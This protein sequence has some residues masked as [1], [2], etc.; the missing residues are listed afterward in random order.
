MWPLAA[1]GPLL[2]SLLMR[3]RNYGKTQVWK[4]VWILEERS[5]NGCGKWHVLVWNWVRIWG[6]GRHTPTENSEEYPPSP[7]D[8]TRVVILV[9]NPHRLNLEQQ[10]GLL[11]VSGSK[12]SSWAKT[13]HGIVVPASITSVLISV[14]SWRWSGTM[15]IRMWLGLIIMHQS[16][17]AVPIPPRAIVGHFP[18]L[19]IPGVGH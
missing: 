2:T 17:P 3:S 11:E 6:T 12:H 14:K 1:K 4:R 13:I 15:A 10:P 19:S 5:E 16:I 7:R 8:L 18:A 9:P